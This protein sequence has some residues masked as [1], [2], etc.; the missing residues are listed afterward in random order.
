[1]KC[2]KFNVQLLE[3]ECP[4]EDLSKFGLVLYHVVQDVSEK[5]VEDHEGRVHLRLIIGLD[6]LKDQVEQVLPNAGVLFFDHSSLHLH[7][8]IANLVDQSLVSGV[9]ALQSLKNCRLDSLAGRLRQA[10]PEV[11]IVGLVD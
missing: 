10:L 8:D 7:R 3:L 5:S 4:L 9:H 11:G 2:G 1:M 6:E